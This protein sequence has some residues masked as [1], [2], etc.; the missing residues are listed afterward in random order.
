[1]GKYPQ[2]M[3]ERLK[4]FWCYHNTRI[5]PLFLTHCQHSKGGKQV[6]KEQDVEIRLKG[7][8]GWGLCPYLRWDSK[9]RS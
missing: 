1:M 9:G 8:A 6:Q 3:E 7:A 2:K 5:K 4:A